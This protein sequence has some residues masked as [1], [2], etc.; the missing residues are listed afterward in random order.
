MS[1]LSNPDSLHVVSISRLAPNEDYRAFA[2]VSR[3]ARARNP[4]LGIGGALLFDGEYFCHWMHGPADAVNR[5]VTTIALDRRHVDFNVLH[6]GGSDFTPSH[7]S[8]C[9]GFVPPFSLGVM[10]NV[11]IGNTDVLPMFMAVL[12]KADV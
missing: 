4:E 5:L 12:A 11:G 9:S 3:T 8:W 2:A 1:T 10:K 6:Y 7:H